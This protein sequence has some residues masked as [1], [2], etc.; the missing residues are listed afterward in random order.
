MKDIAMEELW[1]L[2][3]ARWERELDPEGEALSEWAAI[4]DGTENEGGDA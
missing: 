2:M 1:A 4:Y 3:F